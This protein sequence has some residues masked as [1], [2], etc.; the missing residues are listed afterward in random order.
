MKL[1][2]AQNPFDVQVGQTWKSKD[3]RRQ[4]KF[5]ITGIEKYFGEGVFVAVVEY[6][7]GKTAFRRFIQLTRFDQYTKVR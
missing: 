4:K 5:V 1:S 3:K 2:K 7:K 6:G